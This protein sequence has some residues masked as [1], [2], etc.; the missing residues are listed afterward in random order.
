MYT[1]CIFVPQGCHFRKNP[2]VFLLT[3]DKEPSHLSSLACGLLALH[4]QAGFLCVWLQSPVAF[5][6]SRQPIQASLSK[7]RLLQIIAGVLDSAGP[8]HIC[9]PVWLTDRE[10]NSADFALSILSEELQDQINAP[11]LACNSTPT[12]PKVIL[13]Y[14]PSTGLAHLRKFLL[15]LPNQDVAP[16]RIFSK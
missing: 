6:G 9:L 2:V 16:S 11:G 1:S 8:G 10:L 15:W 7:Q 5:A 3:A 12:K 14:P 13:L 4:S